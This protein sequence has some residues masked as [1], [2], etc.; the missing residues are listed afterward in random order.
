MGKGLHVSSTPVVL[1]SSQANC[2]LRDDSSWLV[3]WRVQNETIDSVRVYMTIFL[4]T[5]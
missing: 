4:D 2:S 3:A 1:L 5:F